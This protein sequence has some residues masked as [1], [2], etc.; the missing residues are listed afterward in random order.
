[1][2][3][4]LLVQLKTISWTSGNSAGKIYSVHEAWPLRESMKHEPTLI[5]K[6]K[7]LLKLK[8][9]IA[10]LQM[11]CDWYVLLFVFSKEIVIASK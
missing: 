4:K 11:A 9:T 7:N 1:M 8:V 10:K 5:L 2:L 3:Q 6:K